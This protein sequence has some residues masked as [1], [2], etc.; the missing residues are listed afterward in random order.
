MQQVWLGCQ[1]S[2]PVYA[3]SDKPLHL[4]GKCRQTEKQA[5]KSPLPFPRP[6]LGWSFLHGADL[7]LIIHAYILDNLPSV[8]CI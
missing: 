4:L 2:F 3:L 7:Q 8:I 1:G 6:F 5:H